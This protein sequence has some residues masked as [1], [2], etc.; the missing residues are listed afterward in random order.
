MTLV[1][2]VSSPQECQASAIS[3]SHRKVG[4]LVA[5]TALVSTKCTKAQ[6]VGKY[7]EGIQ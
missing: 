2:R 4:I 5:S 3:E 6:D 1:L 7:T